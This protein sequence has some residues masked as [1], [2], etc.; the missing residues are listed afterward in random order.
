MKTIQLVMILCAFTWLASCSNDDDGLLSEN[1]QDDGRI[2]FEMGFAGQ[3]DSRLKVSTSEEDFKSSW[4]DGD[5]IG[6]Y[7]VK[8]GSGLQASGNYAD[9]VEFTYNSDTWTAATPQ[10][11]PNDGD[12]LNFYA[13]YPYTENIN[14]LNYAS[15][16]PVD[17]HYGHY[18]YD[19]LWAKK[20]NIQKNITPV[21]LQ[22]SH[23]L[24]MIQLKAVF[25]GTGD[26]SINLFNVIT[27]YTINLANQSITPGKTKNNIK[28]WIKAN[29]Q[30]KSLFTTTNWALVP[31]QTVDIRFGWGWQG[32]YYTAIPATNI[33]LTSGKINNYEIQ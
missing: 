32:A 12:S 1:P 10:Y 16:V 8:G 19:F 24:S 23:V 3:A 28:M 20:E 7:I 13:Y 6:V 30:D 2:K 4:Q 21:Q 17:Q 11:Y 5:K 26:V 18:T 33:S 29:M 9:N 25:S 31:P 22:F 15:A 14:P 27:D